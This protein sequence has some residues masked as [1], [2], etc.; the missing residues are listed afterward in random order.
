MANAP[1]HLPEFD[2]PAPDSS[3]PKEVYAFFGLAAYWAQVLEREVINFT[4]AVH[5][6]KKS[7]LNRRI[8]EELWR[9]FEVKTFGTVLRAARRI[10]SIPADID[11]LLGDALA[12]RNHLTHSFF[13][14][15]AEWFLSDTGRLRMMADLQEHM[16]I[17]KHA[18]DQLEPLTLRLLT[19]FGVSRETIS[20]HVRE[21][22]ER[23]KAEDTPGAA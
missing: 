14:D 15:R 19:Q 5:M 22:L 23:A 12:K 1:E 18:N 10:T 13:W 9:N 21:M 17:F 7:H 4:V 8:V 3:E 16:K 20:R 2:I 6:E 11:E